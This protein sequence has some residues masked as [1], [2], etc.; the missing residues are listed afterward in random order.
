MNETNSSIPW[1]EYFHIG[2]TYDEDAVAL[3][4]GQDQRASGERPW[5]GS[6]NPCSM[7]QG[8]QG[9][10]GH[11]EKVWWED[12]DGEKAGKDPTR[13]RIMQNQL[14]SHVFTRSGTLGKVSRKD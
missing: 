11:V 2:S 13:K 6:F 3:A 14:E 9:G 1:E 8:E 4:R 5:L 10:S 7:P 12:T